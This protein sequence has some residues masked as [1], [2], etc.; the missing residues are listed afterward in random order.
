[1]SG[2]ELRA[3]TGMRGLAAWMVVAYHIRGSIAGLPQAIEG[4]LAKGYLAVD[5]FFLLSGFVIW[6]TY[7]ERLR[8]EG[9]AGVPRFLWRR[10][11]RIWPLHLVM[12]AAA[13]AL[14]LLLAATGRHDPARFPF[15]ELPLHVMLVQNWGTTSAL[16]WNDPAWSISCELA[17]YMM[18]PALA[19]A[20]DWRQLPS[21]AVIGAV[22]G[23]VTLL[24]LV[25]ASSGAPTLGSDITRLGVVRCIAEFA[26][27]NA[28]ASLWIR[29]QGKARALAGVAALA[30]ALTV[31]WTVGLP[32]TLAVPALFAA[33]LL[34]LALTA[35][36]PRNPL[37]GAVVHYLGEISYATYLGHFLLFFVFKLAFV[38]DANAVPA[39]QVA[40]YLGLVLASS[41]ILFHWVERPAQRILN[42]WRPWVPVRKLPPAC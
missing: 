14:A 18:F 20:I 3:L 24:H 25:F 11:A 27:G 34:V 16:S 10:L 36:R 31:G 7:A 37:E 38:H 17:A 1:M 28:V 22:V 23:I 5:F 42:G 21:W 32:E 13:V 6:L 41:A 15:A 4:V 19:M 33:L 9:V 12:L 35:G 39:W 40:L 2:T 8:R 29:W 26:A 30:I